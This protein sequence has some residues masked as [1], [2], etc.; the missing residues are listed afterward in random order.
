MANKIAVE[1]F[2]NITNSV[3]LKAPGRNYPGLLIQGDSLSNL[4]KKASLMLKLARGMRLDEEFIDMAEE[5]SS[6]LEKYLDNY[7]IT[8]KQNAID[9][10]YHPS[11]EEWKDTMLD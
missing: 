3:V 1:I 4:Y 2:N 9:I 11:L 5:L 8:L 7:E 10:P 6:E